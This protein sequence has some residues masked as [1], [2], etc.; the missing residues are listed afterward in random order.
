VRLIVFSYAYLKQLSQTFQVIKANSFQKSIDPLLNRSKNEE[1]RE[2]LTLTATIP[3]DD[4]INHKALIHDLKLTLIQS[5]L[6]DVGSGLLDDSSNIPFVDLCRHMLIVDGGDEFIRPR[7]VGLLFFNDKPDDFFPYTQIDIVYFPQG[8]SGNTIHE[9]VFK[10]PIHQQLRDALRHLQNNFISERIIKIPGQAEARRIFNYPYEAIE[11]AL[12]N[13]VYHRSYEIREPI[14]VRITPEAIQ[15]VSHP[16][17]DHSIPLE[18]I[19]AGQIKPRR[20]RN[21]RIGEFLKELDLTE[22]RGTGIPKIR[23]VIKINGSPEPIFWTDEGR[24]SFFTEIR[25]HPDFLSKAQVEAQVRSEL[26][27]TETEL[28]ILN[29]CGVNSVSIREI[30]AYMQHSSISGNIKK[31]LGRLKRMEAITYTIPEKPNSKNQRY[32]ITDF[33]KRLLNLK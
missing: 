7:N 5:Y 11:E 23:R 20:Y 22:G 8:E 21:R 18:D 15:I 17:A 32:R 2:L 31:A 9:E 27:L 28:K 29:I 12:V 3:F 6:H 14:E 10:G 1:L 24:L 16:G 26:N 4:R 33:G 19:R 13:A 25:I 30:L